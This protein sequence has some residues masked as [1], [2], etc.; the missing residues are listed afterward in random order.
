LRV[1]VFAVDKTEG[2]ASEEAV[3]VKMQC[4]TQL[5][6]FWVDKVRM[7]EINNGNNCVVT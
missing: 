1:F 5:T 6:L 7:N 2:A 4:R 3:V